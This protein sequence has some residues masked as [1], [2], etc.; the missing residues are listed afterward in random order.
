[1]PLPVLSELSAS[2]PMAPLPLLPGSSELVPG[3]AEELLPPL[4]PPSLREL[5]EGVEGRSGVRD[6]GGDGLLLVG[7]L[8]PVVIADR[9]VVRAT[10]WKSIVR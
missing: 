2:S 4:A 8:R 7:L 6:V 1:M 10:R 3:E 9:G 5:E